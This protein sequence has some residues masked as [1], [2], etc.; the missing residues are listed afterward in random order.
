MDSRPYL[1]TVLYILSLWLLFL[2][3]LIMSYD[4]VLN[5]HG[6]NRHLRVI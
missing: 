1:K 5:R 3:L 6:F 2:S 4:K